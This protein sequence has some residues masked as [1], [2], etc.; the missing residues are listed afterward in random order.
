MA[1]CMLCDHWMNWAQR[2]PH[3]KEDAHS[4]CYWATEEDRSDPQGPART[5]PSISDSSDSSGPTVKDSSSAETRKMVDEYG[6][7]GRQT[8]PM[9]LL[10][11]PFPL[12]IP[13][14]EEP[15]PPP[16]TSSSPGQESSTE[17][18]LRIPASLLLSMLAW[19]RD[20]YDADSVAWE[21]LYE[22]TREDGR[23]GLCP[24]S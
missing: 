20:A 2:N 15:P 23:V 5:G 10:P 9:P 8:A 17:V 13:W 14:S 3:P 24:P 4:N 7:T 16:P 21:L 18:S 6:I 11:N 22:L 1:W 12:P 19:N